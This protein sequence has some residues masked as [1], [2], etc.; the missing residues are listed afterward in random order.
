MR[1]SPLANSVTPLQLGIENEPRFALAYLGCNAVTIS[2]T[3]W[4]NGLALAHLILLVSEFTLAIVGRKAVGVHL[5]RGI[6]VWLAN[7]LG[8][9]PTRVT[10]ANTIDTA[11]TETSAGTA[12]GR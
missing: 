6:A 1:T 3:T 10:C 5:A 4:T 11:T 7:T 2:T 8:C 9:N 12:G